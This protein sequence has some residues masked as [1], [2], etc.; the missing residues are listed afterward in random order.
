[1]LV[2]NMNQGKIIPGPTSY[3]QVKP[4]ESLPW[5]FSYLTSDHA[6]ALLGNY[7]D[8][9]YMNIQLYHVSLGLGTTHPSFHIN[10]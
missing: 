3:L 9:Y 6:C 7:P 1:M 5:D 8:V 4:K 10:S 2:V